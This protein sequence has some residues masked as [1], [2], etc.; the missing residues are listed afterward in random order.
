VRVLLV[1]LSLFGVLLLAPST[2]EA[3]PCERQCTPKRTKACKAKCQ[4]MCGKEPCAECLFSCDQQAKDC[5]KVCAAM[6]RNK[7]NP[8]AAQAE[9]QAILK[10]RYNPEKAKTPPPSDEH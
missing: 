5:P 7:G 3:G 4:E 10:K 2:S 1:V 6:L 9:L 8:R